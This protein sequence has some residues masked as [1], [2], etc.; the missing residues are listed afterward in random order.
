[1]G[2]ANIADRYAQGTLVALEFGHHVSIIS[3]GLSFNP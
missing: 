1:M 3:K 2:A